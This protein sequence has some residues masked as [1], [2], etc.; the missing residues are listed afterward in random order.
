METSYFSDN[1]TRQCPYLYV[2]ADHLLKIVIDPSFAIKIYIYRVVLYCATTD[3]ATS[4]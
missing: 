4:L 1:V 3:F 2:W